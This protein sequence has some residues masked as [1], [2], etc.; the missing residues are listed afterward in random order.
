MAI[1]LSH[2]AREDAK[3]ETDPRASKVFVLSTHMI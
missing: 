2:A 3:A 1:D